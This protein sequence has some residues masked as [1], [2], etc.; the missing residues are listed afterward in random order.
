MLS[1]SIPTGNVKRIHDHLYII[2]Y[3]KFVGLNDDADGI[4]GMNR[5]QPNLCDNQLHPAW[6]LYTIF[7]ILRGVLSGLNSV[8]SDHHVGSFGEQVIYECQ[9]RLARVPQY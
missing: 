5:C 8:V 7:L 9:S 6:H 2:S 3:L 4:R 1:H